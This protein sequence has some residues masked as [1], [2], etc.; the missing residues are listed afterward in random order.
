LIWLGKRL[1]KRGLKSTPTVP[2]LEMQRP[3]IIGQIAHR[4]LVRLGLFFW[5]DLSTFASVLKHKKRTY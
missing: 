2:L 3:P 1:K 4:E 5:K